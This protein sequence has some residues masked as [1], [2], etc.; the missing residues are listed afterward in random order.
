[1]ID[2]V[3][4][5]VHLTDPPFSL[6]TSRVLQRCREAG[7]TKLVVPSFSFQS[8]KI[9]ERLKRT[10]P[11]IAIA[12]GIHPMFDTDL[13]NEKQLLDPMIANNDCVAVG[14]IGLHYV[15]NIQHGDFQIRRFRDQLELA[16]ENLLPVIIHCVKAHSDCISCLKDFRRSVSSVKY[17][18]SGVL[19]RVTCSNEL[20]KEYLDMGLYFSFGPEICSPQRKQLRNLAK[21]IPENRLLLETDAPYARNR[22]GD[23][24]SPWD[25]PDILNDLSFLRTRSPENLAAVIR[26][27]THNLLGI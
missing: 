8:C 10:H 21:Y 22:N 3:D 9:I 14:E 7:V 1:M 20:A 26:T 19:H 18:L 24:V 23:R 12:F 16:A 17:Q 4:T 11:E 6:K 27:N 5:H 15:K 13:T 2:L 25:L